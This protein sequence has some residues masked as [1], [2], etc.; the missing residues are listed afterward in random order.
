MKHAESTHDDD[1]NNN[2][3]TK[4]ENKRGITRGR[5]RGTGWQEKWGYQGLEPPARPQSPIAVESRP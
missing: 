1:D 5:V 3:D 2:N 4:N